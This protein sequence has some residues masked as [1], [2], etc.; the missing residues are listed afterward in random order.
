MHGSLNLEVNEDFIKS[1]AVALIVGKDGNQE[2]FY[3]HSAC[4]VSRSH[5]FRT[6]LNSK[7][8]E[9]QSLIFEL[10]EDDPKAMQLFIHWQYNSLEVIFDWMSKTGTPR[11]AFDPSS[12]DEEFQICTSAFA[13]G[14]KLVA[15]IFKE[16]LLHSLHDLIITR[17]DQRVS[18]PCLIKAATTVYGG[19]STEDGWEMR[20]LLA[21]YCAMRLGKLGL[22]HDYYRSEEPWTKEDRVLLAMSGPSEFVANVLEEVPL[23]TLPTLSELRTRLQT[24]SNRLQNR[25]VS[26]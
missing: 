16:D 1:P 18:M 26:P 5:Y 7:F 4:L 6:A 20:K 24:S 12:L 19:T 11:D 2:I 23:E 25:Y 10:E 8:S 15:P 14:N 21:M 3:A 17:H 22:E 13:L 9:A